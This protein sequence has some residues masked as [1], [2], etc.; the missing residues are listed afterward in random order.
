MTQR[1]VA[2]T[3]D[4]DQTAGSAQSDLDLYS[5]SMRYFFPKIYCY[6]IKIF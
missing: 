6:K 3:R 2:D 1:P 5:P 4:R